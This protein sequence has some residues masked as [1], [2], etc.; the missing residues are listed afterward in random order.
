MLTY[1][2][3]YVV[4]TVS[5]RAQAA[6]K[7]DYFTD[8]HHEFKVEAILDHR[9][10]QRQLQYFVSWVGMPNHENAWLPSSSMD[11][12]TELIQQYRNTRPIKPR[13]TKV[14]TFTLG[15]RMKILQ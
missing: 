12:A 5:G 9:K 8:G 1:L 14:I 10:V 6:P 4:D 3:P 13:Q 2:R 15:N 11:K 7:P